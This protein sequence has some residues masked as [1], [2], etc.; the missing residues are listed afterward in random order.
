MSA[1]RLDIPERKALVFNVQKYNTYDGPGVRT[2]VF[3][4]GCP[5]RCMWCSN[6]ESLEVGYTVM[7]KHD[8]CTDCGMCVGACPQ[9]IHQMQAGKHRIDRSIAC[10]GCMACVDA[11]NAGAL[12]IAG[13]SRSIDD[14]LEVVM[15]DMEFYRHS[16]GGVTLGGGEVLLQPE[17]AIALLSACKASGINTAIETSGYAPKDR[18]L[19]F[20]EYTDLF[21][22]DIKQMDEE[23]HKHYTGVSN[24]QILENL[25]TLLDSGRYN[26]QIRLPFLAGINDDVQEVESIC[27]FLAPYQHNK[28]FKGVHILPYHRFGVGK[29]QQV[30]KEYRLPG[31]P[32]VSEEIIAR[33]ESQFKAR[34]I[35]VRTI[36][37]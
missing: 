30:D 19:A 35:E 29:Y 5:L 32:S 15:D 24:K 8:A 2:V 12:Q 18:I 36:R 13:E 34:G 20:A 31:D 21:L 37:H 27:D 25:R 10:V 16:G 22:Y 4:K 3:F 14:L 33:A 17:A 1:I 26:V 28:N 23:K 7:I 6:P 9:N 11:C